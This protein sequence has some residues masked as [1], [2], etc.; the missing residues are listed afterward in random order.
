M[1]RH[2]KCRHDSDIQSLQKGSLMSILI[3]LSLRDSVPIMNEMIGNFISILYVY[4]FLKLS[5]LTKL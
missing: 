4:I 1:L 2:D 5:N 3:Y